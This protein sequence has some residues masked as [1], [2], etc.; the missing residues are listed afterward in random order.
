MDKT[1]VTC[2]LVAGSIDIHISLERYLLTPHCEIYTVKASGA[3]EDMA[4]F[5]EYLHAALI[6][7]AR[8]VANKK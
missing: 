7:Y 6:S 4:G 1:E 3:T 5:K 2:D 8:Q